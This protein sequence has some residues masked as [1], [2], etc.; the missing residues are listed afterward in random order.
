[1]NISTGEIESEEKRTQTVRTRIY[2]F[3]DQD[4]RKTI[5]YIQ[6][7]TDKSKKDKHTIQHIVDQIG[8]E[9]RE[10]QDGVVWIYLKRYK[11][12]SLLTQGLFWVSLSVILFIVFYK[13]PLDDVLSFVG[14]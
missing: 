7:P 6:I 14:L 12:P 9:I 10:S 11:I 1:M 13:Y 2:N 8:G 5:E 3:K 4:I